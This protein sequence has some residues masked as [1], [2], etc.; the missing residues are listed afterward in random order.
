MTAKASYHLVIVALILFMTV[1][2]YVKYFLDNIEKEYF[3]FLVLDAIVC[4]NIL[5]FSNK[6]ASYLLELSNIRESITSKG[7]QEGN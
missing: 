2:K 5:H 3:I 4:P 1:H 7:T 6:K